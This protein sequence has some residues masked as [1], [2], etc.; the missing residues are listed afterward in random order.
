[1]SEDERRE[2]IARQRSALY[3]GEGSYSENG[4]YAD[5]TS[6]SRPG[7]PGLSTGPSSHRGPSL[8]PTNMRVAVP[9]TTDSFRMFRGPEPTAMRALSPIRPARDLSTPPCSKPIVPATR[10]LVD[11]LLVREVLWAKEV[12][13]WH[14]LGLARL[15]ALKL[16]TQR[17]TSA[18]PLH[19]HRH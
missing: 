6:G 9:T 1:M 13:L 12:V 15:S 7:G 16:R 8:S 11:L 18:P 14:L 10:P 2:L 5:E 17:L 19:C 4:G 3:G